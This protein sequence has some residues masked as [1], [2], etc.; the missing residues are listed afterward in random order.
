MAAQHE[1]GRRVRISMGGNPVALRRAWRLYPAAPPIPSVVTAEPAHKR[2]G[3]DSDGGFYCSGDRVVQGFRWL[4]LLPW[5]GGEG[6]DQPEAARRSRRKRWKPAAAPPGHHH[7]ALVSMPGQRR[8]EELRLIVTT[9]PGL[10]TAG[11]C[12]KFLRE[13]GVADFKLP[14]RFETLDAPPMTAVGEIDKQGLRARIAHLIAANQ[15]LTTA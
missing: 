14:D 4:P 1:P 8:W 9:E 6:S 5:S 3:V 11:L 13:R 12:V 15:S 7:A 2:P 10:K